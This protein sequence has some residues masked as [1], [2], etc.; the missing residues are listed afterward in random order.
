MLFLNFFLCVCKVGTIAFFAPAGIPTRLLNNNITTLESCKET[1]IHFGLSNFPLLLDSK[2]VPSL[3]LFFFR[4]FICVR[5]YVILS[6]CVCEIVFPAT[7]I[8]DTLSNNNNPNNN[9]KK[10]KKKNN[11]PTKLSAGASI[12]RRRPKYIYKRKS[13][14][15]LFFGG[16]SI[17]L[18]WN[19]LE[20]EGGRNKSDTF[21]TFIFTIGVGKNMQSPLYT[22]HW[23]RQRST[24]LPRA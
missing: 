23:I 3:L 7:S 2:I 6:L 24:T 15:I 21:S 12:R 18:I 16:F 20:A 14:K 19:S 9:N 4:H 22:F 1:E 17:R 5:V 11:Q 10:T 8:I 13:I